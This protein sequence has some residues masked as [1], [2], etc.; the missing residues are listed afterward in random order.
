MTQLYI[1]GHLCDLP[2]DFKITLVTENLY[3]SKASTYTYDVKLPMLPFS[4]NAKI[5]GHLNRFDKSLST[6]SWPAQLIVDNKVIV[7]GTAVVVGITEADISVQLLQGNSELNWKQKTEN[8]YIDE[9]DLGDASEWGLKF[10]NNHLKP[11]ITARNYNYT[12][13]A[14]FSYWSPK[15]FSELNNGNVIFAPI[16]NADTNEVMNP[17]A[18]M[19]LTRNQVLFPN[20]DYYCLNDIDNTENPIHPNT[21]ISYWF[22]LYPS[23]LAPQPKL[24]VI[25]TKIFNALQMPIVENELVGT[26]FYDNFFVAN[27]SEVYHIAEMLPHWTVPDFI[28]QLQNLFNCVIDIKTDGTHIVLRK[29]FYSVEA[30]ARFDTI[31]GV[32]D[33]FE[34]EIETDESTSVSESDQPKKYDIA[35]PDYGTMFLGDD[36]KA[37]PIVPKA[38]L[39]LTANPYVFSR[40]EQGGKVSSPKLNN[41]LKVTG[42]NVDHYE[43]QPADGKDYTIL[44][45]LPVRPKETIEMEYRWAFYSNNGTLIRGK[46]AY[47]YKLFITGSEGK[48]TEIERQNIQELLDALETPEARPTLE[49]VCFGF[50]T[51]DFY[52]E[53]SSGNTHSEYPI[54]TSLYQYQKTSTDGDTIATQPLDMSLIERTLQGGGVLKNLYEKYYKDTPVVQLGESTVVNFVTNK[55]LDVLKTFL[56]KNQLFACKQIKYTITA[57]GFEK[58]AEGEFYKL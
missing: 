14:G 34:N 29:N 11:N 49:K 53:T 6:R 58:I 54:L 43:E 9:L 24:S 17:I 7:N 57:R 20:D 32:E 45:L 52:E 55:T 5:F 41:S 51:G 21:P 36:F 37:V 38:E 13:E 28:A 12:Y 3:F 33:A 10:E 35:Y 2:T 19:E 50:L 39:T 16:I 48:D 1:D 27:S 47:N 44:K 25:I 46:Q 26:E 40:T 56:I 31:N 22:T 8:T 30:R 18:Y 15:Q 23:R 4:N 42:Y